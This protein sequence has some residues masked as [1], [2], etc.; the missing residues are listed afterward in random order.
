[1]RLLGLRATR[2]P[3]TAP[4]ATSVDSGFTGSGGSV[5]LPAPADPFAIA[6]AAARQR[7]AA[8]RRRNIWLGMGTCAMSLLL[9]AMISDSLANY[10]WMRSQ[11]DTRQTQLASLQAQKLNGQ[12]RLAALRSP[13]GTEEVL[14]SHGYIRP[15][16]RI[17]LFPFGP[18]DSAEVPGNDLAPRPPEARPAQKPTTSAWQG[19]TRVLRRWWSTLRN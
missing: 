16:D 13:K 11:V 6:A 10:R 19:A 9:G 1:M 3:G 15:G 18:E 17:L 2:A 4:G 12:R 8:A 7:R 5:A 14:H